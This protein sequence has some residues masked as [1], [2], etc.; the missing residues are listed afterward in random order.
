MAF[1][2]SVLA[3]RCV[4]P[5][6]SPI[7][8]LAFPRLEAAIERLVQERFLQFVDL[9]FVEV[10]ELVLFGLGA[11]AKLVDLVDDFAEVVAALNLVFDLAEDFADFVFG[12]IG[13]AGALLEAVKIG[14]EFQIH[15]VAEVVAGEGG[16]VVDFAVFGFRRGPGFPAEGLFEEVGILLAFEL[17]FGGAVLFEG[18]EIFQEEDSRGLLGVVE[19]GGAAGLFAENVVNIFEN[20][21]EH[22]RPSGME[23]NSYHSCGGK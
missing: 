16:V 14:K 5:L 8:R 10:G 3:R 2:P 9:G 21:F 1:L 15:K 22:G 11:E 6:G 19:F 17:G 18:V 7:G 13:I 4:P 12:G 20:L 23:K